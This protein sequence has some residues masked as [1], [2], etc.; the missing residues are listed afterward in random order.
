MA[1]R[2]AGNPESTRSVV[3]APNGMVATSQ[4][5]AANAGLSILQKGGNAF[6]AAIATAAVLTV[7]EPMQTGLGGDMFALLYNQENKKVE[8][9]N[10]SGRA[11]F[12]ASREYYLAKG[13]RSEER[14]V[15]KECRARWWRSQGKE[16]R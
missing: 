2:P 15:G 3:H 10:G 14:R 8:A 7:V 4:P 12:K 13:Y 1:D 5:L 9:I 11:P 6:D 16:K